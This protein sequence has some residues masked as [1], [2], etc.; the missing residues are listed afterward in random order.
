MTPSTVERT[1]EG[2]VITLGRLRFISTLV[3]LCVLIAGAGGS[4]MH[5]VDRAQ[6]TPTRQEF[7]SSQRQ[8]REHVRTDSELHAKLFEHDAFQDSAI[9]QGTRDNHA[10]FCLVS[11]NPIVFCAD[12]P[13]QP[14]V[15]RQP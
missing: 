7:D 13:A 9:A 14:A 4:A 12:Q 2:F 3:G 1:A 6:N 11:H 8:F 15:R 10:L 5:F